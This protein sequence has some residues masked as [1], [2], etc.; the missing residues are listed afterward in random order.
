M[1]FMLGVVQGDL[2]PGAGGMAPGGA[3]LAEGLHRQAAGILAQGV[4]PEDDDEH[5]LVNSRTMVQETSPAR[6]KKSARITR[7][8]GVSTGPR[9]A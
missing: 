6:R 8:S 5:I 4:V 9:K 3:H 1:G 2:G 7:I